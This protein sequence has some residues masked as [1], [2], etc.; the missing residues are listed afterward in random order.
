MCRR[1]TNGWL[2]VGGKK[3]I[4]FPFL[5]STMGQ[6]SKGAGENK[7][8]NR[9]RSSNC[10]FCDQEMHK[11]VNKNASPNGNAGHVP[12]FTLPWYLHTRVNS[13]ATLAALTTQHHPITALPT[14]NQY[15]PTHTSCHQIPH[16][17]TAPPSL[18]T[19]V[20]VALPRTLS[21]GISLCGGAFIST[22]GKCICDAVS[23][24]LG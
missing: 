24:L 19:R 15:T 5:Q 1:I 6:G 10:P 7:A 3:N 17:I 16:N 11:T 13:L 23:A 12:P 2:T 4:Y 21:G 20:N 18:G 14:H 9:Y 8:H 22:P